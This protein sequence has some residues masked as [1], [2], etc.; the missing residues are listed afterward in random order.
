MSEEVVNLSDEILR[1]NQILENMRREIRGRSERK[2][3]AISNYDKRLALIMIKLRN[4]VDITFE[5]QQVKDTPTTII[6]KI[7]RGMCWK[8]RLEM[9]E[10]DA[11]Y[12][13][14]ITNI[15]TV[16][17]EMNGLQSINKHLGQI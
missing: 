10:A 7:A 4:G 16:K 1:K 13:S 5:G 11:E 8:E 6:E 14:L 3:K 9:E 12:K 17:A 15:E 2:A